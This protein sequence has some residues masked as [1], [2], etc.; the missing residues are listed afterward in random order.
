M[1][2]LKEAVAGLKARF[3]GR[4]QRA[5]ML[6][7]GMKID[8]E[9]ANALVKAQY[10]EIISWSKEKIIREFVDQEELLIRGL[11]KDIVDE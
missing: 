7:D 11:L 5:E 1:D 3:A 10:E 8:K 2:I 4:I 6:I 9:I